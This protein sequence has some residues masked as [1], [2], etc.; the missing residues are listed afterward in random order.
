MSPHGLDLIVQTAEML[1]ANPL[2]ISEY[3]S[4]GLRDRLGEN[5]LIYIFNFYVNFM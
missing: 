2:L 3:H 1:I 5:T 4:G